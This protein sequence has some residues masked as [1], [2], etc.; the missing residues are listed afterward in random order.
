MKKSLLFFFLS[1]SVFTIHSASA[2]IICIFCYDQNDSISTGVNNLLT[3]GGFENS[4]CIPWGGGGFDSYCPSSM[5][6]GCDIADWTCTGGGLYSYPVVFDGT[7]GS[8]VAEG[9]RGAYFG[10]GFASFCSSFP[11]DTSCISDSGC[12]VTGIP[13]GY[14]T[15]DPLV[16]GPSGINLSQVVNGLT[17]GNV[18]ILEFWAGGEGGIY[19][20]EGIF[21][22]DIGFGYTFLRCPSTNPNVGI[23]R[24]YIIE[25]YATATSHTIKFT[26]WGHKHPNGTELVLDDVRLYTLAELSPSVPSCLGLPVASFTAPDMIC[27]GTC[28]DFINNSINASTFTWSFPGANPS[29]STDAN[30]TGICYSLPGSYDVTLIASG[31]GSDTLMLPNYITV[32]P[33]PPPQGILQSGDSLIANPGAVSY[34][35]FYNGLPI[36]GATDYFYV[37]TESGNY[38]VVA[39]DNN[40]CEVEAVINNVIAGLNQLAMGS[41]QLAIF[42]NPVH[43]K[44]E[45]KYLEQYSDISINIFNILGTAVTFRPDSY[46]DANCQLPTCSL[47]VSS[48]ATGIYYLEVTSDKKIYRSKFIKQ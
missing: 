7:N 4:T 11:S 9:I 47:D 37:A 5:Y 22:V 15:N 42:P 39:T 32:Y 16:G 25:F 30:P 46:R 38:N 24:R 1:F 28:I 41:L 20:D 14:P 19:P 45:V 27:P 34:Q 13:A 2:Q 40:G 18:Y 33:F 3:N 17:P 26:S 48:L 44:L 29:V 36:T 43:D 31:T 10:N 21:A 6:Y 23:G 8:N 35:W 12:T